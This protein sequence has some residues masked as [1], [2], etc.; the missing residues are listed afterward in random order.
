MKNLLEDV[1]VSDLVLVED[2]AD[3]KHRRIRGRFGMCEE[4]TKNGRRYGRPLMEREI[5]RLNEV[6]G[7]DMLYGELDHPADGRTLLQRAA[8]R[9]IKL[10]LKEDGEVIGDAIIMNTPNGQILQAIVESGGKVGVSSRGF[11]TTKARADGTEDVND[12]YKLK[13]YDVVAD[14]SV[15]TAIPMIESIEEEARTWELTPDILR[16]EFPALYEAVKGES[17]EDIVAKAEE[18][19]AGLLKTREDAL[20]EEYE[21]RV[22]RSLVDEL[23]KLREAV[24]GEL[25]ESLTADPDVA[26]AKSVLAAVF[27]LAQPFYA[28][29]DDL[30]RADAVRAVSEDLEAAK[31]RIGLLEAELRRSVHALYVEGE[32]SGHPMAGTVRSIMRNCGAESLDDLK[33]ALKGTLEELADFSQGQETKKQAERDSEM[34][35]LREDNETMRVALEEL[36]GAFDDLERKRGQ[37]AT[38]VRKSAETID[39]VERQV[40]ELERENARLKTQ[41]EEATSREK[42]LDTKNKKLTE[43]V[44]MVRGGKRLVQAIEEGA[45][46]GT[47]VIED[48]ESLEDVRGRVRR[49]FGAGV[50]QRDTRPVERLDEDGNDSGDSVFGVSMEEIAKAAGV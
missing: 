19:V 49:G 6:A 44:S 22:R 29:E 43:A 9:I 33:E 50:S 12:D 36:Q 27:E 13:S 35:T 15:R 26:G 24:E 47:L 25:R 45:D 3:K 30:A 18:M 1:C 46:A 32:I 28:S 5:L 41:A 20:R 40:E 48:G 8:F 39:A 31:A 11:G 4:A 34:D 17:D 23:P 2:S 7:S 42:S 14:P 21:A 10:H 16:E 37:Y 38:S